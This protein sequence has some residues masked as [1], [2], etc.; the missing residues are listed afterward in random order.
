MPAVQA[1]CKEI[2]GKEP[3]KG[4]NP[5]EVVAIGASIQGGVIAGEVRDVLLLDVTPLTL[6]IET[7]GGVMTPLISRNTTIPVSKSETFSTAADNQPAVDIH[8]LQGE[9]K[10]ASGNRTLGKF[11]LD[12]I[13]PAPRGVPQVEVTFSIDNNGILS[14][15]ARDK[16]TKKEQ[17]ITIK[18]AS[19]LSEEEIKQMVKDAADHAKDDEEKEKLVQLQNQADQTAYQ[20]GK[21]LRDNADKIDA[22]DREKIEAALKKLEEVK[23]T[24]RTADIEAALKEVEAAS[25]S[26]AQKMYE[27]AQKQKAGASS[28]PPPAPSSD[29]AKPRGDEGVVDADY[30]VVDDDKKE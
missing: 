19:G 2:F 30:T 4:V 22:A 28:E 27:Q 24:D 7:L 25:H 5:D 20:I 1:I 21:T 23:G 11:Q 26:M 9:R 13:P 10:L 17:S 29:E 8:V 12:G 15:A 18:S 6:G 14:V 16:A 3:N